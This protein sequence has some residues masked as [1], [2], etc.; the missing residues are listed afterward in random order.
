MASFL[1]V[2]KLDKQEISNN[3]AVCLLLISFLTH[4]AN[5]KMEAI[6]RSESSVD[7][8][9]TTRPYSSEDRTVHSHRRE[10]VQFHMSR[11]ILIFS[12]RK[13]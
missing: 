10:T 7:F 11:E 6:R 2:K 13:L 9:R 12:W 5:L 8:Y 1:T 4:S 3:L